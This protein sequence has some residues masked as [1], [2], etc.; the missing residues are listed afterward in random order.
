[1]VL[2]LADETAPQTTFEF[3]EWL[4][5]LFVANRA[6]GVPS[7]IAAY[8][9]FCDNTIQYSHQPCSRTTPDPVACLGDQGVIDTSAI[10]L[11]RRVPRAARARSRRSRVVR[12]R[13]SESDG[14]GSS[15][16]PCC[17]R[18]SPLSA[19]IATS[20]SR[21]HFALE[22]TSARL[23]ARAPRLLSCHANVT[24]SASPGGAL[25]CLG[26]GNSKENGHE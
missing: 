4:I 15:P 12:G 25:S 3:C 17:C 6:K 9:D 11:P 8:R 23:R 10:V 20:I 5:R 22:I 1:M 14:D 16:S 26:P 7:W 2:G 19:S 21:R 18:L 13:A 24:R